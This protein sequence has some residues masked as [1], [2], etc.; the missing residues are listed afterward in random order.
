MYQISDSLPTYEEA[1]SASQAPQPLLSSSCQRQPM[2]EVRCYDSQEERKQLEELADLY[3]IFRATESIETAYSRS[4]ILQDAYAD[5]CTRLIGQFKDAERILIS[6]GKI[7]SMARFIDEYKLKSDC[8]RALDRLVHAG[9]PATDLYVSGHRQADQVNV[10]DVT[11]NIISALDALKLD[12]RAVDEIKPVI[13][14]LVS[15]LSR[16]RGMKPNREPMLRM[17]AWLQ[18]LS[19]LRAVDILDEDE[20]RQLGLDLDTSLADFKAYLAN[21]SA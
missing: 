20:A 18:K 8:P 3:S 4:A 10:M 21:P 13:S 7:Q 12:H 2:E 6:S 5:E 17:N 19:K 16:V 15:S 9:V 1:T 14:D 11:A